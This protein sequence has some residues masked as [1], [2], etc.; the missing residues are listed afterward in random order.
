MSTVFERREYLLLK[1]KL[2]FLLEV[3]VDNEGIFQLSPKLILLLNQNNIFELDKLNIFIKT[4]FEKINIDN[5]KVKNNFSFFIP[6]VFVF[7]RNEIYKTSIYI[8][9][10]INK[11]FLLNIFNSK[12]KLIKKFLIFKFKK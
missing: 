5:L 11:F 3:T 12:I 6:I 8:L 1:K 10:P 7:P 9:N 4:F 2:K